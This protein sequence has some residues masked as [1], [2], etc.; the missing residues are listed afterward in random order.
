MKTHIS[1]NKVFWSF[2]IITF[3]AC[4]LA[5]AAPVGK[6]S[7]IQGRVDVLKAGK[8]VAA[9]VSLGA[10]VDVGDI[11]RTKTKSRAVITFNN[12][13][14]LKIAP[15]TRIEIQQ[16]MIEKENSSAVMKLYRGKV[17][18]EAHQ[19]F[20]KRAAAFAEGN[21]FEVHTPN[22][23]AGIRGSDM[24]VGFTNGTTMVV[25]I[26]GQGYTYNPG[27]PQVFVPIV[28]G[29]VSFITGEGTPTAPVKASEAIISGEVGSFI[30]V[31]EIKTEGKK[32]ELIV[33]PTP[34]Y[35]PPDIIVTGGTNFTGD[36][37]GS[38][39][40]D[41]GELVGIS[42]GGTLTGNIPDTGTGTLSA[43][44]TLALDGTPTVLEGFI[45]GTSDKGGAFTG[46][47]AGVQGSWLNR[48]AALYVEGGQVYFLTG[49]APGTLTDTAFSMSGTFGKS[50]SQGTITLTPEP[51]QTLLQ[52]LED[53]VYYGDAPQFFPSDTPFVISDSG[54]EIT[55]TY[56]FD[57]SVPYL[58]SNEGKK[59]AAISN[60][61][62]GSYLPAEGTSLP[63][64]G[65]TGDYEYALGSLFYSHDTTNKKFTIDMLLQS[66]GIDEDI[67][68]YLGV[69][70]MRYF[71][72][73]E[74][75]IFR[76]AGAGTYVATP[77]SFFGDW[78][79]DSLYYNNSGVFEH[80]GED[81][82]Y[83]GGTAAPWTSPASFTAMGAY[84]LSPSDK[85]H[86]L[87]N[88]HIS[89]STT[90]E[91]VLSPAGTIEGYAGA[92][93]KDG[94][95]TTFPGTISISDGTLRA[96]Y[97][98]TPV[99][100]KVTAGIMKSNI[101]GSYYPF[102]YDSEAETES[103][104]WGISG[105][106]TPTQHAS[107]LYPADIEY[108]SGSISAGLSGSF[109]GTG[110]ITG[111]DDGSGGTLYLYNYSTYQ[112]LPFGVFN[113]RFG[114]SDYPNQY[115]GKPTGNPS[116][117]A[118]LGGSASFGSDSV[119]EGYWLTA[120]SG[121]W[122]DTGEITGNVTGKGLT[123][124]R[125]YDMEGRFTGVNSYDYDW[126]GQVIGSYTGT[127]L[128]FFSEVSQA[129]WTYA[130]EGWPETYD[131]SIYGYMGG[132]T[133]PWSG[134]T[135]AS[136]IGVYMPGANSLH[137]SNNDI[138]S[139]N[140]LTTENTTFDSGAYRGFMAGINND[141]T[142][143]QK[144]V[145]IYR[146]P[147]AT[148][149]TGFLRGP[150]TGTIYSSI[151]MYE[152]SGNITPTPMGTTSVSPGSFY[153]T[154]YRW[155]DAA[156]YFA[157]NKDIAA[158][159][160]S[161]GTYNP[162]NATMAL[163]DEHW[164]VFSQSFGGTYSSP[165]PTWTAKIGGTSVFGEIDGNVNVGYYIAS[166]PNGTWA[167]NR[168]AGTSSGTYLSYASLGTIAGDF[169]G[170]YNS[171]DTWQ[172]VHVG[173][174]QGTPLQFYSSFYGDMLD[175]A[176]SSGNIV[177]NMLSPMSGN[178]GGTASLWSGSN[179]PVKIIGAVGGPG[180][181][182]YTPSPIYSYNM[183]TGQYTYTT[184]DNGAYFGLAGGN[185]YAFK[186]IVSV[187]TLEGKFVAL[188]IDNSA[189][190][191]AGFL[192]ANLSGDIY[193]DLAT[194]MF[195]MDGL[196][197]RTEKSINIGMSASALYSNIS[198][199][200][201]DGTGAYLSG[202]FNNEAAISGGEDLAY[203]GVTYSIGTQPWGIYG[204][205]L[206]G[207][208]DALETVPTTWSAKVGSTGTLVGEY[209]DAS[210]DVGYWLAT[211]TGT[212]PAGATTTE[213]KLF[214][215]LAGKYLTHTRLG[216][217]DGDVYGT[218]EY[219]G[220]WKAV[221][222][223]TWTG[224]PLTSSLEFSTSD[225]TPTTL[226]RALPG[227]YY[228]AGFSQRDASTNSYHDYKY[229]YIQTSGKGFGEVDDDIYPDKLYLPN[230]TMW[231]EDQEG[232]TSWDWDIATI[233]QV[234]NLPDWMDPFY[235]TTFTPIWYSEEWPGFLGVLEKRSD[236]YLDAILGM[237]SYPWNTGG[238]PVTVIGK[239]TASDYTKPTIVTT[240]FLFGTFYTPYVAGGTANG[241]YG[242]T[243]GGFIADDA[244][245]VQMAIRGLYVGPDNQTAGV[246]RGSQALT[247]SLY[248][249]M[250][251][252]EAEGT[253]VAN[254]MNSSFASNPAGVTIGNL[255]ENI[256]EGHIGSGI[257]GRL[258]G[259][260]GS[261]FAT[262]ENSGTTRFIKGQDWGVFSSTIWVG[263]FGVSSAT[264]PGTWSAQVG[265]EGQFGA[266]KDASNKWQADIGIMLIPTLS[267]TLTGGVAKASY[268]STVGQ[269][270]TMTKMG[271]ISDV[272]VLG[273]Y[274]QPSPVTPDTL[275]SWQG[276]MGGV[277]NTT[278]YFTFASHFDAS[279][280]RF[281]EMHS[282]GYSDGSYNHYYYNY[283]NEVKYGDI[284]FFSD[285]DRTYI[286]QRKYETDSGS[287]S[288]PA[289][290]EYTYAKGDNT[291]SDYKTGTDYPASFSDAF[292]SNL[293]AVKGQ[294]AP[295]QTQTRWN[296]SH[297]H[298]ISAIM[299]G[300]GDLWAPTTAV[301][302]PATV[303]FL[304]DFN[305]RNG[306]PTIFGTDIASYNVKNDTNTTFD[307]KGTYYGYIGGR[308]I[309]GAIEGR[310]YAVY[311]NPAETT[312]PAGILKGS[313]TGTDSS[314]IEM[315]AGQGSI[316]PI[317][318]MDVSVP[319]G[320]FSSHLYTRDFYD[321]GSSTSFTLNGCPMGGTDRPFVYQGEGTTFYAGVNQSWGVWQ[322]AVGGRYYGITP[323]DSW[324][325]MLEFQDTT[326]IMG[327][328][329]TG[330]K[331]SNN[332]LEG[333]TVGYGADITPAQA[334][335]WVSVGELKGTFNPALYTYQAGIMG[336]SVE[337]NTYLTLAAT[338]AGQ[339][340]LQQLGIPAV[341]VGMADLK[342]AYGG[343]D[344]SSGSNG[345][346]G[347]KFFSATNGGKPQIWA[348]N[349]VRGEYT[350][351]PVGV[352]VPL[353]GGGLNANFT[354]QQMNTNKWLAGVNGSGTLSGGSY[355]GPT[356]FKGAAAG[357]YTT[358]TPNTFV[359]TAAG[360]AR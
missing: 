171:D 232:M 108:S 280:K 76:M 239:Y 251:M 195:E 258:T 342:G 357:K 29:Q 145:T 228:E 331:W 28:A 358:G 286:T 83:F 58:I 249:D 315:W 295:N 23:V 211:I 87:M 106:L 359:G 298:S 109:G 17:Q 291:F 10:A 149:T 360:V 86:Y 318:L 14:I 325:A 227:T 142:L 233:N 317:Y 338:T 24:I 99:E 3:L 275:Y 15:A 157:Y 273:V 125:L 89:G 241:A 128:K 219:T 127:D 182:W 107:G 11:Y 302:N 121:T 214:G 75:D 137:I 119:D 352:S 41:S 205:P 194:P 243:L 287:F 120:A 154:I 112:S 288:I 163:P 224:T 230:G 259:D 265:A 73:Y 70:S 210:P 49:D 307:G 37:Y 6:I 40:D 308:E 116:W 1:L 152:M 218:Y 309:D 299:G 44:G 50:A 304:G 43:S 339:A 88:S 183:Y 263:G 148:G 153:E 190:P 340:K 169:L 85:P 2:L 276:I 160:F 59:V 203:P 268:T 141:G 74:D 350:S 316:Y 20:A 158:T 213:G 115:D 256:V 283:D 118:K 150:F 135:A 32:D 138:Y 279:N 250:G 278:Q 272:G 155:Q 159:F 285:A 56:Y 105:T 311:L 36:I 110:D 4:S 231:K 222:L 335:T 90:Q 341:Q 71:G 356:Q 252:W 124:T 189:T 93:W 355:T 242:M 172:G 327:N 30:Q 175:A 329:V 332:K 168:L 248:K 185:E 207:S 238:T 5:F 35:V 266:Y 351:N 201:L 261:L 220:Y 244:R 48:T 226:W 81:Y 181:L 353:S 104:M 53:A 346:N 176:D 174:W 19:D 156:G 96:L 78:G 221:A 164:G 79:G 39:L 179:I 293:A 290:Y 277:W 45:E 134:S 209:Q 197:N 343:V 345:M 27:S 206:V 129:L 170:T 310:I 84:G 42:T 253:V 255:S 52:A 98:S 333:T 297:D 66:I 184:Y 296:F 305:S 180:C 55:P 167:G 111:W 113:I 336:V 330:T 100:G 177:F 303:Y 101:S 61:Y 323:T 319:L 57:W 254:V 193:K 92:I 7:A 95:T 196:V 63:Y 282:G 236:D 166:I 62:T 204:L 262:M 91:G 322:S 186:D 97:V 147:G 321:E 54:I 114:N 270:M 334:Y 313:F 212:V 46:P 294:P 198:E 292:F 274:T 165:S 22:A 178:F 143:E 257:M 77:A 237:T 235:D 65:Y 202:T 216:T 130:S 320:D 31:I 67:G 215:T 314:D 191:K 306:K 188:Y 12:N 348:T 82:G 245:G 234:R 337:T 225:A 18:A 60:M 144:F 240:P 117:S 80:A 281:A 187:K 51:G 103:G 126:I 132:T 34:V 300:V 289:W 223:G 208:F 217:M 21:R 13:N 246:L 312:S 131:A 122:T 267:G 271:T 324:T 146:S 139:Y 64:M 38:M 344:M 16:Y 151:G 133:A 162:W 260:S 229:E 347:V 349:N 72:K 136:V 269:F 173:T 247:G 192:K 301:S 328:G 264:L 68:P 33:N 102:S 69:Y 161:S 284:S 47:L 26:S 354:M 140:A 25:F 94:G 123:W 199:G 200:S 8:N 9:P 326:R